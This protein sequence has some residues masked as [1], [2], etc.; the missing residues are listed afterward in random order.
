MM[1]HD[2]EEFPRSSSGAG[3]GRPGR[4]DPLARAR[5][6][7]ARRRAAGVEL[8]VLPRATAISTR[9]DGAAS[10][11]GSRRRG[12]GAVDR[13]RVAAMGHAR[14]SPTR[15]RPRPRRSAFR[16]A[17]RALLVSPTSPACLA[18]D[19]L[20]P[21]LE[22]H[23]GS[24]GPRDSS[25]VSSSSHVEQRARRRRP[26]VRTT[27]GRR[28]APRS[29]RY[30]DRRRRG[31]KHASGAASAIPAS[32][33]E[34][35]GERLAV[36]F[37]A[38]ALGARR[39]APLR[40]LLSLDPARPSVLPARRQAGPLDV[41]NGVESAHRDGSPTRPPTQ[42]TRWIRDAAGDPDLEPQIERVVPV[43][44]GMDSPSA[45]AQTACS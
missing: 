4:G 12:P 33:R 13:R 36:V 10:L 44:F 38:P 29:R 35:L 34:Q 42:I 1:E 9:H 2:R 37:R 19:Q 43:A 45:F 17:S 15:R 11:V 28:D 24:F 41:R 20:E 32:R 21:L 30:R 25:A 14:R 31:A 7:D 22:E 39:R 18:Q 16:R 26:D 23:L 5:G 27:A 3:P 8:D 40:D 6:R